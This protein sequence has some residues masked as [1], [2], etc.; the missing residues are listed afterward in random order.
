MKNVL[1]RAPQQGIVLL[2]A[3]IALVALSLSGIVLMRG[4]DTSNIISGNFAFNEATTQMA[5]VGATDAE[6]FVAGMLYSNATARI[7]FNCNSAGPSLANA[8]TTTTATPANPITNMGNPGTSQGCPHFY[9]T[10]FATID[11]ITNL[12]PNFPIN[13]WS[14][15][16]S[17]P[18]LAEYDVQYF[19]ERM[20]TQDTWKWDVAI[21]PV[22]SQ[23]AVAPNWIPGAPTFRA[24]MATPIYD[25]AGKVVPGQG[26]LY[27][28]VT[29]RVT[30]P[31]ETTSL[32]QYYLGLDDEVL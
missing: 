4:V 23:V 26:R 12:P 16:I 17:V 10:Y 5:E 1:L 19:I 15:A 30:G 32:V 29:V 7:L 14:P 8:T 11:P 22:A 31:R 21:A 20:C 28:R 13:G 25:N 9:S 18:G 2:V 6:N 27:Y 24:C 3:L